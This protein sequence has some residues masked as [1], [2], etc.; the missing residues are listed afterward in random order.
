MSEE[1]K[2]K[3]LLTKPI[4]T[5]F[6]L[7]WHLTNMCE[8]RCSH[9]YIPNLEKEFDNPNKL[10]LQESRYIID[11]LEELGRNFNVAPRINFSGG[12]PL[13]RKDFPEIMK[14]ARDKGIIIGIL[15]NPYPLTEKN[16]N[17]LQEIG[18]SR[19]QLSLEGLKETH[20][21]IR[22]EGNYDKTLEAIVKLNDRGIW[23]SIMSTVSKQNYFEIPE[24]SEVSFNAGA[25]H[26]DFARIVPIGEGKKYSN[27]QLSPEEF[28]EFLFTMQGKYEELIDKG[29]KPSFIGR[30]DPLWYLM[31]REFGISRPFDKQ[32]GVIEGCS[33]GKNGLC[34]DVD[35]SIYSCR[36][37]PL[38]IGNIRDTNLQSFFLNSKELNEQRDFERIEGCGECDL[39]SVCRGCRAV[40]YA[41]TENYFSRDPQCWREE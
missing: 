30:K 15:G 37:M 32:A 4:E 16:L 41:E 20:D 10:N 14:Y 2:K 7:Q 13:L 21:L 39:M 28:R 24:L 35:G 38:S 6:V 27:Q 26:F 25:K 1:N 23:V 17:L 8:N 33:I 3:L 29:A 18:V 12:N 5:N 34:L 11:D 22:G 9:C 31:D 19:Y 40:A 36:R